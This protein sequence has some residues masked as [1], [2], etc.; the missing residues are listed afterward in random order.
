MIRAGLIAALTLAPLAAA[1]QQDGVEL[2]VEPNGNI[3]TGPPVVQGPGALLR[4]LDKSVGRSS[5]VDLTV[6]ETTVLGRIAV[7]LLECRYPEESPASEAYAHLEI[8]D[9]DGQELFRGWMIASSPALSAL[10]HPRY[11]LWV[12]RCRTSSD[13]TQDG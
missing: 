11:D 1:A 2:T 5:D 8:M 13:E 9:L 3:I 12:L 7:R 10:E 6:G 4:L